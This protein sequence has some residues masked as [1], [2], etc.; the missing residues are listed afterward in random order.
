MEVLEKTKIVPRPPARQTGALPTG[1][2]RPR[3]LRGFTRIWLGHAQKSISYFSPVL[4]LFFI[5]TAVIDLLGL[6][7]VKDF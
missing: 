4:F 3:V 2:T 7:V 5:S 6:L 1:L